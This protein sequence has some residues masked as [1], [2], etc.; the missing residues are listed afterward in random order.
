MPTGIGRNTS[1]KNN[2]WEILFTI[3]SLERLYNFLV[4]IK[5]KADSASKLIDATNELAFIGS[6]D[7]NRALLE[8]K[9]RELSDQFQAKRSNRRS[10]PLIPEFPSGT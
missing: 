1:N 10:L 7:P 9:V 3:D 2:P 5:N 6:D 4:A 8:P